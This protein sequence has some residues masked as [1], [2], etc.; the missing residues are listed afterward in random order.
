V[1]SFALNYARN[2]LRLLRRER[3]LDPLVVTYYLTTRCNLN[4]VYC[5]DFGLARNHQALP[6]LDFS[7]ASHILRVIRTAT[8]RVILTGGEPLL[9]P[10][11]ARLIECAAEELKFKQITLLT[12]GLL[13]REREA[14]LRHVNRLVVSL[15]SSE[16]EFWSEI[17][18]AVPGSAARILDNIRYAAQLQTRFGYT[19]VVNCVV[20]PQTLAGVSA[21][22]DLCSDLD[23]LVSFSPQSVLNWPSYDLLVS[24][25]YREFLERTK[26]QKEHGAPILGSQAYFE[27]LHAFSPY[28]CY[29]TLVPRVWPDGSLLYPCR[30]IEREGGSRGGRPVNLLD[31]QNWKEVMQPA[32]DLYGQPPVTCTS[33]FQQC[34]A[35]PSLMQVFPLKWLAEWIRFPASRRGHLATFAPG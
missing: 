3:A 18:R 21:L 22:V 4:C 6:P 24:Q 27:T 25:N 14:L 13:L 20:S 15:D 28:A 23:I 10:E 1:A 16:S 17:I 34:F 32:L 19:L 9:F 35:E 5:E 29:P 2:C 33:C 30:P 11:I 7:Q 12:N 26:T 8:D 31:V